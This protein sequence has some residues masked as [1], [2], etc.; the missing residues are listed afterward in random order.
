MS[1]LSE[2]K[3]IENCNF[4]ISKGRNK[5]NRKYIDGYCTSELQ[6][7]FKLVYHDFSPPFNIFYSN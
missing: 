3:L 2:A 4:K 6:E 7:T 5:L 1:I